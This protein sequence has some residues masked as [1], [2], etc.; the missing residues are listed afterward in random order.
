MALEKIYITLK[1]DARGEMTDIVDVTR[2]T[3]RDAY[4]AQLEKELAELIDPDTGRV[5][6]KYADYIDCPLCSANGAEPLFEVKGY[7][8]VRCKQCG[9][10]Y[11]NPQVKQEKLK[12]FYSH[13]SLAND[14]WI[15]VLL[16]DVEKATNFAL[17]DKYLEMLESLTDD[18]FLVDLGCGIGDVILHAKDRGWR[19]EGVD[20]NEKASSYARAQ[21]HL[22]VRCCLLQ[23]AG[24]APETIPV[25]IVTGVL[26]HLNDPLDFMK[27]ASSYLKPG[28]LILFQVPNLHALGNMILQEQS[29]SFDGRNHLLFF[30]I[31]TLTRLC[32]DTGFDVET[33]CTDIFPSHSIGKYLQYRHPYEADLTF[34]HLPPLLRTY[35]EDPEKHDNLRALIESLDMGQ[36]IMLIARRK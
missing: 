30:S 18:R 28:G 32:E 6:L 20:L 5:S 19:A 14:M 31:A 15:D 9:M 25:L 11:A 29:T 22:E 10:V 7:P 21:R 27:M 23:D 8:H 2:A 33:H 12:Q 35:F 1:S 4:R 36:R 26:E 17:Y 34:E 24:Y 16:A 13:Q 3:R